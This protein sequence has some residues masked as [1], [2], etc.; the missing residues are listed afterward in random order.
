[1]AT[2]PSSALSGHAVVGRGA[3]MGGTTAAV[4]GAL[5][6]R[7]LTV[8]FTND[9]FVHLS[10]AWQ[11]V[12]GDVPV[13]DFFDPGALLQYYASAAALLWSGHNLFGEALLTTGF[14]AAGAGLTFFACARL[15]GSFWISATATFVSVLSMPRLYN[16]PKVFFYVLAIVGAWWY[17][18]HPGR[19][20]TGRRL[21]SSPSRLSCSATT[22]VSTSAMATV[23]LLVTRHWGERRE[24]IVALAQYALATIVL[25]A[26]YLVF[27]ESTRGLLRYVGDLAPQA[28]SV[29][30]VRTA[31]WP[32]TIDRS[33][34]WWTWRHPRGRV[35]M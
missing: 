17:A 1:M 25:L 2:A 33:E 3:M 29:S 20:K 16:Y 27:I 18:R 13:R 26:P 34:P 28:Q 23:A 9:H 10:R 24:S 6:V 14:I 4:L 32:M 5:L 22:T 21:P 31:L 30:R 8:E 19:V 15:S 11:V 35:S 7:Y 12:Q